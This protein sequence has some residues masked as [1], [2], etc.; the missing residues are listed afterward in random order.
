MGMG[1]EMARGMWARVRLWVFLEEGWGGRLILVSTEKEKEQVMMGS[2][3]LVLDGRV[4]VVE[5]HD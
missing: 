2:G 1:M 3:G 4:L 5:P